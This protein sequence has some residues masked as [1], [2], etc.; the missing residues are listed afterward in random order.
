MEHSKHT[1]G[2]WTVCP[3]NCEDVRANGYLLFAGQ[4]PLVD[5]V[6]ANP[7]GKSNARLIA[8]A[9]DMLEELLRVEKYLALIDSAV[10]GLDVKQEL[11]S[12]RAAIAKA[13]GGAK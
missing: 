2:P 8:A 7:E 13:E 11:T 9:P 1:P 3:T 5:P 4:M 12:V 10:I 6:A